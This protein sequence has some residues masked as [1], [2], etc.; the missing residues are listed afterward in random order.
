MN[1]RPSTRLAF[2]LLL[3]AVL[4]FAHQSAFAHPPTGIVVNRQG[5]IYFTDLET[6][7][8]VDIN[9]SLTVFRAGVTGRHV[10]ELA[11][12][13]DDNL[14]GADFSHEDSKWISDVWRMKPNGELT[15]LL[16]PT[17][18]PPRAFSMWADD[19]GNMYF[20]E[21][22]NHLKKQKLLLRRTPDDQVTT[23]AGSTYGS[24]DGKGDAAS[25]GSVGG[26]FITSSGQVYLTDGT[27]LRKVSTAGVVTTIA[28]DLNKR[29]AEDVPPLFGKND[30]ILTGL[31]VDKDNNVYVADAGN[32]RLLRVAPSGK[33][34]VVYRGESPYYP[35][36][37]AVA[38]SG[39]LYVLEVGFK[40]PSTWLPARVRKMTP[41][42][43]NAIVAVSGDLR[44]PPGGA[45]RGEF[46][47]LMIPQTTSR[48][49]VALIA[50]V[51]GAVLLGLWKLS[52][53]I[54]R[55]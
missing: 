3:L 24:R 39:D 14:L 30:G 11:L 16:E 19:L 6:V 45:G 35:N 29:T 28:T 4:N 33:F 26:M 12:D 23:L 46:T 51:A 21:Q 43:K 25:F 36:G 10:H 42:G 37:V 8:K 20:V 13:K 9:G 44:Q 15:Y 32:Q 55:A 47:R 34:D 18:N 2:Q 22:D 31:S 17:S 5:I 53:R 41:E 27:S 54:R 1:T 49:L 38:P 52:G 48:Y 40:P 50:V 7:W